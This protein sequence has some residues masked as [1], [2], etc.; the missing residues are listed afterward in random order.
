MTGD[1]RV[2]TAALERTA[3][4][5]EIALACLGAA[6]VVAAVTVATMTALP[7]TLA[8]IASEVSDGRTATT[9]GDASVVV[10]AEWI[11][12]RESAD[13]VEVRTPDGALRARLDVVTETPSQVIEDAELEGVV[14]TEVLASGLTAVHADAGRAGEGRGDDELSIVA[15]VG[16]PALEPSVRVVVTVNA[17][18]APAYR[19]AVGALMEGIRR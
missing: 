9:L 14:R 10:P 16:E 11:V 15:G 4:R 17:A 18:D 13:A 5:W 12:R 6:L 1:T 7:P 19:A 2:E 8:N 3:R